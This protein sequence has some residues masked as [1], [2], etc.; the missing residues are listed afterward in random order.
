MFHTPNIR[1]TALQ[2]EAIGIPILSQK[3]EG[4]K[5]EELADLK[6]ALLKA[7]KQY[8]IEG[9]V[10]GALASD[11][12]QER[13]NRVCEDVGLKTFSPLWHKEQGFLLR[14]MVEC[15]FDIIVQSIAAEGLDESWLGRHIDQVALD[16]LKKLNKKSGMH[17]AGEGGEYESFVL[18]G[19][20]FR[21]RLVIAKSTKMSENKNTG[22]LKIIKIE[23]KDK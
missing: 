13:V 3:T 12:Q 7:K 5:E 8:R 23:L 10:V 9:L 4:K 16:D 21:K 14:E 22:I 19:P 15:G 1:F 17:I 18:D 20:I 11:Y 2:A 6:S